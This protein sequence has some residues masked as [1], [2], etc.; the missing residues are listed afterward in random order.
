MYLYILTCIY[1]TC[2]VIPPPPLSH[3][4]KHTLTI[5]LYMVYMTTS[6][7]FSVNLWHIIDI[8][9]QN[10]TNK[11]S[12]LV[13]KIHVISYW[14]GKFLILMIYISNVQIYLHKVQIF[15]V[16]D[17]EEPNLDKY[18]VHNNNVSFCMA[19]NQHLL[20]GKK[21]RNRKLSS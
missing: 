17:F 4:H 18:N 15:I 11:F 10:Y 7:K 13:T 6:V 9:W 21:I 20:I 14:K 8:L 12:I 3:T 5:L 2:D 19:Q 16:F 1:Y